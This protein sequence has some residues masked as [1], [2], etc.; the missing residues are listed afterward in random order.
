MRV[1]LKFM[2]VLKSFVSQHRP[3]LYD[4]HLSLVAFGGLRSVL[5]HL[6]HRPGFQW[7]VSNCA[8][9]RLKV[10]GDEIVLAGA[11]G[12]KLVEGSV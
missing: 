6:D 11:E 1:I 3:F 5:Y 4:A 2:V 9:L 8:Y 10:Q 12:V 7:K